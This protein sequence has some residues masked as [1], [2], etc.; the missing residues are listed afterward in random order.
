MTHR[1]PAITYV[2]HC[3]FA[4]NLESVDLSTILDC[5]QAHNDGHKGVFEQ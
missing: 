3:E 4:N 5:S 2:C 1:L